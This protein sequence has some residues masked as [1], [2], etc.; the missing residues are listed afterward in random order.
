MAS[1]RRILDW[2]GAL[3]ARDL[4]GIPT[5]DGRQIRRGALVRSGSIEGLHAD[6]WS[7]LEEYGIRTV[8]DLRNASEVKGDLA[9]RPAS[10]ETL[11]IPLDVS[12]DRE[13]WSEW[14]AGPQFGTPL[15]YGPHLERFPERSA[16]VVVAIA[17]ARPG[18]VLFH[19]AGGRDRSGQIAMLV[20]AL[21]GVE[22]AEIARDYAL[23]AHPD[24]ASEGPTPGEYLRQQGTSATEV[25]TRLLAGLDVEATLRG[26]GLGTAELSALRG[27]LLGPLG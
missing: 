15:Y 24:E 2:P 22:P 16:E 9:P 6:G 7:Q 5:A 26:G 11:R 18:G 12:E 17:R 10:I 13:F 3:N 21:A 4:G 14:E 1:D 23:T 8:I 20:L 25:L 19:C 27:R